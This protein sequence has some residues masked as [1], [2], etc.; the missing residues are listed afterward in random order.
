M[1]ILSYFWLCWAILAILAPTS[2]CTLF[3]RQRTKSEIMCF[4]PNRSFTSKG[5]SGGQRDGTQKTPNPVAGQVRR[6]PGGA[7][8]PSRFSKKNQNPGKLLFSNRKVINLS[9]GKFEVS[10]QEI[11]RNALKLFQNASKCFKIALKCIKML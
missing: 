9:K 6:T 2:D 7:R 4:F 5:S 11:F 1:A 8:L 3:Q 10:D